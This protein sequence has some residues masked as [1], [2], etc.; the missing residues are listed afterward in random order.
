MKKEDD[1]SLALG[2]PEADDPSSGDASRSWTATSD[3]ELS[4]SLRIALQV[5]GAQLAASLKSQADRRKKQRLY[6]STADGFAVRSV[7]RR[8]RS[9]C[10]E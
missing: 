3:W 4:R 7:A 9:S 2:W 10:S 5:M 6:K 1:R 8:A